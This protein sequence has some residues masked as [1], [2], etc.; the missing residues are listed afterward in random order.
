MEKNPCAPYETCGFHNN[1]ETLQELLVR[2]VRQVFFSN[3]RQ[4]LVICVRYLPC[5]ALLRPI[6]DFSSSLHFPHLLSTVF[7]RIL[8]LKYSC[9]SSYY[10]AV[11]QT[12]SR[13]LPVRLSVRPY[14][15]L[16]VCPVRARNSKTKKRRKF[17]IG[18]G[19]RRAR[20]R[21]CQFSF[22]KVKGKGHQMQKKFKP[23]VVFTY[24]RPIKRRRIRRRLQTRPT[25]L[26]GLIYCR[27]LRCS[28][29]GATLLM[30]RD[31]LVAEQLRL[32]AAVAADNVVLL[33]RQRLTA[34]YSELD[35]TDGRIIDQYTMMVLT[36]LM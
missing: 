17:K 2:S 7:S 31:R 16:T 19:I 24:G 8:R 4:S 35:M 34:R 23:G 25:P 33:Q 13:V 9:G 30:Q 27:R 22:E 18:I 20:E 10:A 36:M 32:V 29:T 28:A 21:G 11:L 12:A 1:Y 5:A 26:L 3:T 14:L 15:C 6:V